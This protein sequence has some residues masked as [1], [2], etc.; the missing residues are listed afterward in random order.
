MASVK[1]QRCLMGHWQKR[2]PQEWS[3]DEAENTARCSGREA[4]VHAPLRVIVEEKETPK[5]GMRDV[6]WLSILLQPQ[7]N[8]ADL[9][10]IFSA[11]LAEA[12]APAF[13]NGLAAD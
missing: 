12:G 4:S 1:N 7:C 8:S 9:E 2:E 13:L 6:Q 5:S 3:V 11:S 10:R